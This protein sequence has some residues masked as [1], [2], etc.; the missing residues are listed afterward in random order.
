MTGAADGPSVL[1]PLGRTSI[2]SGNC[3][4]SVRKT[5]VMKHR[6][7]EACWRVGGV[8]GG[9]EVLLEFEVLLEME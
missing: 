3:L 4:I 5:R 8:V 9:R 1:G 7:R 6:A 2:K